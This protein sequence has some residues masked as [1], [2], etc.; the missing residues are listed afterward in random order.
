MLFGLVA[1]LSPL[2][3]DAVIRVGVPGSF[4]E[5]SAKRSSFCAEVCGVIVSISNFLLAAAEGGV[6][7]DIGGFAIVGDGGTF[8]VVGDRGGPPHWLM[9]ERTVWK[10]VRDSHVLL[11]G[12]PL[13]D[14]WA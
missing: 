1:L 12:I 6:F 5:S 13:G 7:S 4:G 8:S 10:S 11:Q 14:S 3:L 9:N 2:A